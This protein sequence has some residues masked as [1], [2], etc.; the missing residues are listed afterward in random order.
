MGDPFLMQIDGEAVGAQEGATY[1]TF[2][3][4]T[5]SHLADVPHAGEEDVRRAVG[6]AR[7]AFDHGPWPRMSPCERAEVLRRIAA[8]LDQ[9]ADRLAELEVRDN[10][11]TIRKALGGDV[12]GARAAFT[13]SAY[14][15]ETVP[16]RESPG[17]SD[18]PGATGRSLHWQPLGVVASIIPWNL[19]LLLA[20]WRIA[21]AIAVG[22][23]VVV[24]PASFTSLTTIELVRLMGECG[25]PP[26]VVNVVTGAG[27][28][29]GDA[30]VR[31]P[32]VDFVAFTGSDDVGATVRDAARQSGVEVRLDLGGKSPNVVLPDANLDRAATGVAWSIFLHNG[33][34]CM[35][36]SRAVVHRD[37]YGDFLDQ[38]I[39][40]VGALRLGDPLDPA[41]DLGPLVSR[42]Q[43]RTARRFARIG[44]AEGAELVC[45]GRQPEKG[46]LPEALD[47]F[48]Y[49]LPTVLAGVGPQDTVA[50][51]EIF[52]PVL[53]VIPADSEAEAVRIANLSRYD[54]C[55][56]VWSAE[57]ARAQR[58]AGGLRARQVWV[59]D[60]RLVDLDVPDPRV[61][62]PAA[63]DRLTNELDQYRRRQS[64]VTTATTGAEPG[65][66]TGPAEPGRTP[67]RLL[68]L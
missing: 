28:V 3:P 23:T 5:R 25:L 41:T 27:A 66:P 7:R 53:S 10:G 56:G 37:V 1:R 51:E 16:D 34:I 9:D 24:K 58:V 2:E 19:P 35:A 59:N 52:G 64:V 50:R 30:L 63:W 44:V 40:K 57:P 18:R 32:G 33:Q 14:W 36:G 47:A 12:P 54:L 42:N 15:V 68:G 29:V 31:S 39:E 62:R 55:A 17:A 6:A 60:Y 26:G 38:L 48:A 4:A 43:A 45:G 61:R 8:R 46:E 22:N 67:Y 49:V 21:P 20:A 65:E 13:W 11:S